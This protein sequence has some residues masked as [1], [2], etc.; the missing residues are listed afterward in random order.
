MDSQKGPSG[1][2]GYDPILG[3]FDPSSRA[4]FHVATILGLWGLT[5]R[6]GDYLDNDDGN[7]DYSLPRHTC[8]GFLRDII[9]SGLLATTLYSFV[10][11]F[12]IHYFLPGVSKPGGP[13]PHKIP[14]SPKW[15]D[16][17]STLPKDILKGW[18]CLTAEESHE[19]TSKQFDSK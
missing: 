4:A 19:A 6:L 15:K 3:S 2:P 7:N 17:R 9:P 1:I 14:R 10:V 13:R 8:E 16:G 11:G 18:T 5:L 12:L